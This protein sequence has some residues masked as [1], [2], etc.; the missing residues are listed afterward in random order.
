MSF[1]VSAFHFAD[2]VGS[3]AAPPPIATRNFEKS[4]SRIFGCIMSPP[5]NV[6]TPVNTVHRDFFRISTKPSMSRG[7]GTSQFS[8]PIE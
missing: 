5:N 2:V 8:A 4:T 6:L 3:T 7:L 1:P